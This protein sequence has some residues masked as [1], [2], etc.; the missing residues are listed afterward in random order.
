M[1][2]VYRFDERALK[3]LKKLG[4]TAQR[5]I[6]ANLD[7]RIAGSADPRRFGK[8]LRAELAGL[9]RYR[10]GDY[11]IVCQIKDRVLLVLVVGVGHRKDIYA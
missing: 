8:I 3:E 7:K 9:W 1:N 4:R 10:V 11:R 6:I 2:W 5:E